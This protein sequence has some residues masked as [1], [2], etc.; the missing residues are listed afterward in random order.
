MISEEEV[1]ALFRQGFDCGQVVLSCAADKLGMDTQTACKL[2]AGFGG[3]MS[4]GQTCGAVVGAIIALGMKYGHFQPDTPQVK[5]VMTKKA[6]EFQQKF[7]EVYPS[8]TCR[9]LL[10]HD[11][12]DP[13][14]MQA[15]LDKGLLFTFC[16]GVVV[17]T[18]HLLNALL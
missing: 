16:P 10:G 17:D 5:Y 4:R 13:Q 14:G 18:A 11:I 7:M 9:E 3:G 2:A 1:A 6:L 8:T 12:G 15:I